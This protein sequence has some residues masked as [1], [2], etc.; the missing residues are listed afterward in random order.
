MPSVDR[1]SS[2]DFVGM[3]GMTEMEIGIADIVN[4]AKDDGCLLAH[5]HFG[6]EDLVS[7]SD[8]FRELRDHGWLVP[9]DHGR[10]RLDEAAVQRV[11]RR[12]PNV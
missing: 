8:A 4:K 11:Q 6:P 12:F 9:S 5:V 7:D 1:F 10:Y 3:F 2:T